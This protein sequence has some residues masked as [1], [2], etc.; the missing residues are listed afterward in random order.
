M[1]NIQFYGLMLIL[2][3]CFA[4]PAGG[5]KIEVGYRKLILGQSRDQVRQVIQGEFAGEYVVSGEGSGAIV[6]TMKE[7]N[8]P[9]S[10]IM[11]V[12]DKSNTLYK[13]NVKMKKNRSN[14]KPDDVVKVIESKYGPPAK[15]NISNALDLT[16]YWFP[17]SGRYEI[18]FQ[19]ITS[20]DKYEVQYTD[21]VLE[22][23]KEAHDRAADK[24]PVDKRLDF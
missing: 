4:A 6:L 22:K 19:N 13:I 8:T 11:L 23:L 7:I 9:V 3:A 21:T 2:A 1:K 5:Q 15:R 16:A 12:F 14:P 20:W 24:K 17:D 10:I 18:F